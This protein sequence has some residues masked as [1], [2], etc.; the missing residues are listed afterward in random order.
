MTRGNKLG[1]LK[2]VDNSLPI[3]AE[4]A[5][6]KD[7]A[8]YQN[9]KRWDD[10]YLSFIEWLASKGHTQREIADA[11]HVAKSTVEGWLSR[12]PEVR[13]AFDRGKKEA[14]ENVRL[15]LYKMATGFTYSST[16]LFMFRGEVIEKKVT[17]EYLPNVTAAIKWLQVNDKATWC[18]TNKVEF[19]AN[20]NINKNIDVS[21]LSDA[22]LMALEKLGMQRLMLDVVKNGN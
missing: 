4:D 5:F 16:E 22:E 18:E 1:N 9:Q 6:A 12:M 19:E 10:K 7:P 2:K 8:K 20:I 15:S 21:V 13:E 14:N 17:K 3:I 11:L